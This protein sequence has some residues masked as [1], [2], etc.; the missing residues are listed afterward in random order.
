M[1]PNKQVMGEVLTKGVPR[2]ERIAYRYG[3]GG[4]TGLV[5]KALNIGPQTAVKMTDQFQGVFH[6]TD[7]LLSD[8][9]PYLL[10][11]R[12]SIIDILF[13]ANGAPCVLEP[14]YGA[15]LPTLEQTPPAM[16]EVV[17]ACRERPSGKFIQRIYQ[18]HRLA[19]K[20]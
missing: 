8:G 3:Y 4:L 9:R 10:G 20:I 1:L 7:Q 16:Q 15:P 2:M 12:L 13:C 19:K 14:R 5:K 17:K 11:D 6:R 18:Q